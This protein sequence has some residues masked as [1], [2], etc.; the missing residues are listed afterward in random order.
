MKL[1]SL[2][3]L[4]I[5]IAIVFGFDTNNYAQSQFEGKVTFK[6][7]DEGEPHLMDYYVQG[8]KIRFDTKEEGQAGQIIW[9][10]STKQFMVIMPQQKMYMVMEVPESQ[11]KS[12]DLGALGKNTR[13]TKTGE[14]KK[15]LGYTTEKLIY[16]DGKDQGEAWMTQELGAFKLFDNP[17]QKNEDKPQ[18][19]RD[20]EAGGYFPLEVYENG[21]KVFET[22]SIEKKSL[23]KSMFEAPA[24]YQKMDM[25]TMGK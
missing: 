1:R 10:T 15:I 14:T 12:E 20:F 22:I 23:D 21:N 7:F 5:L 2:A 16:K 19:Q 25:P 9:D 8:N 3:G 17:M 4:F 18:W 24:G 6:V 11:M 13:F